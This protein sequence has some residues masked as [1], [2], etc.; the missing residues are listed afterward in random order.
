MASP[1]AYTQFISLVT[2]SNNQMI[3]P[4]IHLSTY[5]I[6]LCCT[7]QFVRVHPSRNH[8]HVLYLSIH[9]SFICICIYPHKH[10][11]SIICL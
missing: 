10:T 11:F 6:F 9:S 1:V 5:T 8:L 4:I 3:Y 2:Q 7:N